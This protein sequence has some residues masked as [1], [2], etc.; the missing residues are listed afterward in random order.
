MSNEEQKENQEGNF[1]QKSINYILSV[2]FNIRITL[3]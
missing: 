2:S 3:N 1:K